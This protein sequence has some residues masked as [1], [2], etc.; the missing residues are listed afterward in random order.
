MRLLWRRT[1]EYVGE[2]RLRRGGELERLRLRREEPPP[3]P[4]KEPPPPP[5]PLPESSFTRTYAV[6]P[7][8]GDLK[9]VLKHFVRKDG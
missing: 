9:N 1:G 5:P 7:W 8:N 2:P 3:P 6:S 4:P